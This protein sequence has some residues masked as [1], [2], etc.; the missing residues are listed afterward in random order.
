[1]LTVLLLLLDDVQTKYYYKIKT[2]NAGK[3]SVCQAAPEDGETELTFQVTSAAEF[4]A[5]S[6]PKMP[7]HWSALLKESS[8]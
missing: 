1:M 2:A 8:I 5:T 3:N 7:N 4:N 6:L